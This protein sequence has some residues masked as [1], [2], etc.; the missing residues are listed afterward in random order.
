MIYKLPFSFLMASVCA[1]QVSLAQDASPSPVPPAPV[2]TDPPAAAV[3]YG[4]TNPV[5]N[6]QEQA[7][8][9]ITRQWADKSL[10]A[11]VPQPGQ[12]GA[13]QF[14]Y[15]ECLPQIVC[16][17]LNVTDIELQPGE[18]IA[19][20]GIQLGDTSGW[21]VDSTKA[22]I[23]DSNSQPQHVYVKPQAFGLETTLVVT[24]DRRTYH[25]ELISHE[26]DFM[27][28]VAFLYKDAPLT[29][30]VPV[31]SPKAPVTTAQR[32]EAG[33]LRVAQATASE[34]A[35]V[36]RTVLMMSEGK[37][38]LHSEPDKSSEDDGYVIKGKAPWR[39]LR[40][41]ND[42]AKTFI[43][44]PR[45]LQETPVLFLLRKGGLLGLG[46]Q[47]EIVNYRYHG[48]WFVVDAVVELAVLVTGVGSNKEQV[49]ITRT[50][51]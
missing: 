26:K 25:L 45:H 38:S 21:L 48:R 44:M 32:D 17:V 4:G 14:R 30:P 49:T 34:P 7:G 10:G 36:K 2:F 6:P 51:K 13:V 28:H 5:L 33:E 43:E 22:L 19:D 47:K 37:G 50:S 27:H 16:A 18:T 39:P 40:V 8:V 23:D 24:T 15:G 11:M 46:H 3:H 35:P 31:S 20:R 41:Y 12:D 42:G 29:K 1:A 9:G